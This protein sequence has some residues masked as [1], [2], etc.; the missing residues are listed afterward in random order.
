MMLPKARR[1]AGGANARA[2]QAMTVEDFHYTEEKH[3]QHVRSIHA[4]KRLHAKAAG[5]SATF[6][7]R[8]A[9]AA[10]MARPR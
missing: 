8:R 9:S 7:A 6:K 5:T 3:A 10:T 1:T 2:A 4:L